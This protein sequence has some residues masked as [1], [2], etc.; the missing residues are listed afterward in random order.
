M[1]SVDYSSELTFINN[2]KV[3]ELS[4]YYRELFIPEI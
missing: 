2:P 3:L 1:C 4:D